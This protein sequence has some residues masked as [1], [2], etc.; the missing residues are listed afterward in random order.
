MALLV[1]YRRV[2][3]DQDEVEYSFGGTADNLDRHLVIEK[4]SKQIRVLD[5]R[6]EGLARAAAGMIFRRF[7]TDGAWPERGV[8][9]S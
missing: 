3:D 5:D 1:F 8:V 6:N 4:E 9:Q 7:R 2:R